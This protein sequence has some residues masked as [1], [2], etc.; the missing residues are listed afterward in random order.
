[1]TIA[2]NETRVRLLNIDTPETVDPNKAVECLGPEASEHLESLLQPGDKVDLE[3]DIEREDR[4]G[5]TLAAVYKDDEFINRSIAAAGLGIAVKYEPN[6]KFY[7]E[8]LEGQNEAEK[9]TSGLFSPEVSCTIASQAS[10]AIYAL[11]QVPDEA[12]TAIDEAE[13]LA[14][15]AAAAVAAGLA[16]SKALKSITPSSHPV[17]AAL[18]ASS[19]KD[20]VGTLEHSIKETQKLEDKHSERR[21]ELIK[22]EKERKKK[23]AAA[24]AK[25]EAEAK[26]KAEEIAERQAAQRAAER[27]AAE[28]QATSQPRATTPRR[29]TPIQPSVPKNYNGPRCYAPGGKTWKPCG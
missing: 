27:Q 10:N 7:N 1:M 4:Y 13:S 21:N 12:A 24:K 19:F 20:A 15:E 2:G 14:G 23:E 22:E 18:L 28:R 29:S 17:T 6:T 8:V 16:T 26:R 9:R 3:Y 25:R 5:R 11:N